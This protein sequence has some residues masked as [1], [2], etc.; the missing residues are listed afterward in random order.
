MYVTLLVSPENY[1]SWVCTLMT[2]LDT[3]HFPK[4]PTS[5]SIFI[6]CLSV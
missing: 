6:F 3:G 5:G 2:M 1:Q 4:G